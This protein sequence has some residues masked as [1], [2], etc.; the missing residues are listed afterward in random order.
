M[1]SSKIKICSIVD[2]LFTFTYYDDFWNSYNNSYFYFKK[3]KIGF[4]DSGKKEHKNILKR[5]LE[6]QMKVKPSKVSWFIATHSH[7][8]HIGGSLIFNNADKFIHEND[9]NML[10][11]N[12]QSSF[13]YISS[14][15]K[16][17]SLEFIYLGHH[18]NG[19]VAIYDKELKVLFI[20]DHIC[21]FGMP[22]SEK[23]L[24]TKGTKLRKKFIEEIKNI[25]KNPKKY[26]NNN[27]SQFF[28]GIKKLLN[29]D[30][31][32]LCSGHGAILRK[33]IND[34]LSKLLEL[35]N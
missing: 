17:S 28:T 26:E 14:F 4:I 34:F 32:Y 7:Q 12:F 2:N 23:G 33:N 8:D 24:I 29:Y 13:R 31:R 11:I 6:K 22:L 25:S 20:G 35:D 30:I 10:P 15:H 1:K 27:L 3:N 5:N 16:K 19:S 9:F 18:T 21:F